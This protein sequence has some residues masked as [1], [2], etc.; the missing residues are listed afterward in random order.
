MDDL[1]IR[2]ATEADLPTIVAIYNESIPAGWSTADTRP[3]TVEQRKGWFQRFDPERRPIWVAID[4]DR[5]V[6]CVYLS[7]FYEGRPAYDQT[8]EISTYI[9]SSHQGRGLGT[10]LKRKMIAAGS[11]LGVEN[12]V[13]LYFNH[14]VATQK[15]N[16]AL[17]FRE[18]G[19]LPGIAEVFGVK[20]GLK[21]GLL[22]LGKPSFQTTS[23]DSQTPSS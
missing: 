22:Q 23:E 11:R 15:I 3:I 9:A 6:G 10:Y 12:F 7:W 13:S 2:D 17:G 5:V 8:A 16:A 1:V 20:R 19:H 18:V 4:Q 21:I 14:N